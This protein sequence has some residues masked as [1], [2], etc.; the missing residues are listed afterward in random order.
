MA[1][2]KLTLPNEWRQFANRFGADYAYW[3]VPKGLA[4]S[5]DSLKPRLKVLKEFEGRKAWRDCQQDYV[6]RLNDEEI[7]VA[8]A[9]W[10]EGGAPLAR[11]LKQVFVMLGLAWV[12]T[13][14][15]VEITPAG[16]KFLK[17]KDADGVLSDQM[18]RYQF[19][20]PSVASNAHKAITL[21]PIPFLGEVL[22]ST[23]GQSINAAEYTLFV[24][25][26]K[27]FK[28][29]DIVIE[30]IGRFRELPDALKALVVKTCDSFKLPGIRRSSIYNTIR[31]NRSYALKMFALSRLVEINDDGGL[32][33]R[34]GA[35]KAYRRYLADYG[36]EGAYI[37]FANEKDWIAYFGDPDATPTIDTALQYY[38]NKG[39]VAAAIATKSLTAKSAKELAEFQD[40]IVSEKAV[41]DYLENHLEVIGTKIGSKLKLVGRQYS[42]TVGPI[43]LLAIDTKTSEYV[44]VELKKGRSAGADK[45]A[46]D[47]NR[48]VGGQSHEG[49]GKS[50]VPRPVFLLPQGLDGRLH[51]GNCGR[52]RQND[53][54]ATVRSTVPGGPFRNCG[55]QTFC[56]ARNEARFANAGR[57][58]GIAQQGRLNRRSSKRRLR[59]RLNAT[60]ISTQWMLCV[61][62]GSFIENDSNCHPRQVEHNRRER[63]AGSCG[64][65]LQHSGRRRKIH[66]GKKV[67]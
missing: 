47:A 39:D 22:R 31:L 62:R 42:T 4:V 11:M 41:E 40:M 46:L 52:D 57:A 44:I 36:R 1:K 49:S 25:R 38:V 51:A 15:R 32:S 59:G 53:R 13:N 29:V 21:H 66:V 50:N 60:N 2:A 16:D 55:P 18:S 12:D 58:A 8:A 34:K 6:Q 27:T 54:R 35:L 56:H 26:A 61:N 14:D 28:D 3:Y 9:E 19:T 33:I 48:A 67:C 20:N 45:A 37:E 63:S 24:G 23:D 64:R 30:Q 5:T 65:L 17:D 10:D 43:D 7:S